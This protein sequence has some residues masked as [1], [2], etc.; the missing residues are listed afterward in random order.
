MVCVAIQYKHEPVRPELCYTIIKI[1]YSIHTPPCICIHQYNID[2]MS[3][4]WKRNIYIEIPNDT[5]GQMP[6]IPDDHDRPK[7]VDKDPLVLPHWKIISTA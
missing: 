3:L 4:F 1:I 2:T 6:E 7:N 5:P